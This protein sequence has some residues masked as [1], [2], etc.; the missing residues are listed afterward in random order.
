LLER[1]QCRFYKIEESLKNEGIYSIRW[2]R[3]KPG[4]PLPGVV[5]VDSVGWLAELYRQADLAFVGGSFR[6]RVHNVLE[7]AAYGIPILTG[8]Y[9]QNS[10]E[11]GQMGHLAMGLFSVKDA[12]ELTNRVRDLLNYPEFARE[13][14]LR[15]LHFLEERR[16]AGFRYSEILGGKHGESMA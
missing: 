3:R 12:S 1:K 14:G 6:R 9:I 8:P 7:P 16:G 4:V 11:A 2:S 10:F 15:A 5:L 13:Q